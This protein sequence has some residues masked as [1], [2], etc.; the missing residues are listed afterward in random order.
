MPVPTNVTIQQIFLT[1]VFIITCDPIDVAKYPDT[2]GYQF[3]ASTE[4]DFTPNIEATKKD[5][6]F[7][8]GELLA[9]GNKITISG[10]CINDVP[11]ATQLK[12]DM[13]ASEGV[14]GRYKDIPFWSNMNLNTNGA[15]VK[16]LTDGSSGT[17]GG[18]AWDE[19]SPNILS[20][21]LSGGI[22]DTWAANDV[23]S[24][25]IDMPSSLV[26][27]GFLPFAVWF[28]PIE[29]PIL[30]PLWDIATIY[31]KVRTFGKNK[32]SEFAELTSDK[33]E[34]IQ[35]AKAV[36]T[37]APDPIGNFIG[38]SWDF[39]YN[40][41]DQIRYL[42]EYIVYRTTNDT[43]PTDDTFE[44]G[45]TP[46]WFFNDFGY[47]AVI[48]PNGPVHNT[49]YYYW[50]QAVNKEGTPG[51]MSDPDVANLGRPSDAILI[52]G[53]PNAE[54]FNGFQDW[55]MK[56]AIPGGCE[57]TEVSVRQKIGDSYLGWSLTTYI[58]YM[59]DKGQDTDGNFIQ[60]FVFQFLWDGGVY[61]FQMNPV[62]NPFVIQM[63]SANPLQAEYTVTS[64]S[65]PNPPS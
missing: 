64:D 35:L 16:N 54:P 2:L 26:A 46:A 34:G 65:I 25:A 20:V 45:R 7:N 9:S 27:Q 50:V 57:G 56:W 63:W 40:S 10:V 44:I 19:N 62:N 49:V 29:Y 13:N 55:I 51:A 41:L 33:Q 8:E 15:T 60:E 32:T 47:D 48:H 28:P 24:M 39:P 5:D 42:S 4:K 31:V 14:P 59:T 18:S 21:S 38:V 53:G 52:Y 58:P 61:Q 37:A 36:V 23:F 43:P 6:P 11:S 30:N 17:L 12:V 3:F 22:D 1:G